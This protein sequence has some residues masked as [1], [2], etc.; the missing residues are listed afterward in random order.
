[1][2]A[3]RPRRPRRLPGAALVILA[4]FAGTSLAE[5]ADRPPPEPGLVEL[6]PV[7]VTAPAAQSE[8]LPRSWVPGAAD[9]L[10]GEEIGASQERVLPDAVRRLP[11]V[12]PGRA[13]QSP[14]ADRFHPGIRGVAGDGAAAGRERLPGRRPDQRAHRG[15]SEL[16]PDS[17]RGRRAAR[18]YPRPFRALRPE[19]AGSGDQPDHASR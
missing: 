7:R 9:L 17:P 14:P 5:G 3:L 15:G 19:Y 1:M 16:R 8:G 18:G 13:R 12:P 6:P 2:V 4:L 11:G 10:E